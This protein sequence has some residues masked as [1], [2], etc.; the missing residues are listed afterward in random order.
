MKKKRTKTNSDI[1]DS[2]ETMTMQIK[3]KDANHHSKHRCFSNKIP[4][5][6]TRWWFQTFFIFT[7]TWG[8]NPNYKMITEKQ[9][10]DSFIS[11]T[12]L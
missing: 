2:N 1:I 5:N 9:Q 6:K 8:N 12:R 3:D 4:K 10:T 7:P 11:V